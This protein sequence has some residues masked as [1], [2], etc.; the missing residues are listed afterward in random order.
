[1]AVRTGFSGTLLLIS[2]PLPGVLRSGSR[3]LMKWGLFIGHTI[4]PAIPRF[5]RQYC[6]T[7]GL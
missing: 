7:I 2:D 6:V 1:M 4:L 3:V 5:Y